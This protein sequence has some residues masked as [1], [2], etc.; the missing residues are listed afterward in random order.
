VCWLQ[1]S[2]SHSSWSTLH[3]SA[4]LGWER[5]KLL[6]HAAIAV[7]R[8]L[9]NTCNPVVAAW[10]RCTWNRYYSSSFN[11]ITIFRWEMWWAS[12]LLLVSVLVLWHAERLWLRGLPM[13]V[14][15]GHV[16]PVSHRWCS[17]EWMSCSY[18]SAQMCS[19]CFSVC[20]HHI[21]TF[22]ILCHSSVHTS[23]VSEHHS[24]SSEFIQVFR[25]NDCFIHFAATTCSCCIPPAKRDHMFTWMFLLA[26]K[27][28]TWCLYLKYVIKTLHVFPL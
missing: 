5:L 23:N 15:L 17:R 9:F 13:F 7:C 26:C 10:T 28:R 6:H 27:C 20:W 3:P 12:C 11:T 16:W 24:T 1:C 22:I 14:I 4:A 19:G 18:L 8:T 21:C 25:L 2:E